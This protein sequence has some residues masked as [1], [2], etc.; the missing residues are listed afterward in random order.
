MNWDSFSLAK[1]YIGNR[2]LLWE[3]VNKILR[4]VFALGH[5][6]KPLSPSGVNDLGLPWLLVLAAGVSCP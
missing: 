5:E 3:F 6:H 4:N 1:E 2:M